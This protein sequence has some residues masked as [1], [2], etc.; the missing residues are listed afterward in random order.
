MDKFP[1]RLKEARKAKKLTQKELA[2]KLG[3]TD[4]RI[5]QYENGQGYPS[6]EVLYKIC[7]ELNVSMDWI[8]GMP[9]KSKEQNEAI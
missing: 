9:D 2:T 6:A 4:A 3:L 8:M 1:E 7:I 5:T